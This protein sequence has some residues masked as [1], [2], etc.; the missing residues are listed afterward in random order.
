MCQDPDF[1]TAQISQGSCDDL[2]QQYICARYALRST[3]KSFSL[4]ADTS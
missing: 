4:I 1:N 2:A 3:L